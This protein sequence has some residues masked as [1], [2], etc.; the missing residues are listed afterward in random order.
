MANWP[1]SYVEEANPDFYVYTS[2]GSCIGTTVNMDTTLYVMQNNYT[3][4]SY[5]GF[6]TISEQHKNNLINAQPTI[7][8]YYGIL[9]YCSSANPNDGHHTALYEIQ[10]QSGDNQLVDHLYTIS[11]YES[12]NAPGYIL[13][14]TTCYVRNDTFT[15]YPTLTPTSTP[16]FNTL[17]PT[18]NPTSVPTYY[19]TYV[20]THIPTI[21]PTYYPTFIP[22]FIPTIHPTYDPSVPTI[23]PSLSPTLAPTEAPSHSRPTAHPTFTNTV[24]YVRKNGCDYGYCNHST[25]NETCIHSNANIYQSTCQTIEYAWNCFL[26]IG[27]D[28]NI[29]GC[30]ENGLN[31][32]GI[33]DIGIGQWY[34]PYQLHFDDNNVIIRGKESELTIFN[35]VSYNSK[36]ITCKWH[37]CWIGLHNLTIKSNR[38]NTNDIQFYMA[39]GG[40]LYV[41]NVIFDGNNYVIS[42]NKQPFWQFIEAR[43]NVE[44][45][46]CHFKNN[47]DMLTLFSNGARGLFYNCTFENNH[48]SVNI[49]MFIINASSVIF[50]KCTFM[51]NTQTIANSSLFS[52]RNGGYLSVIESRFVANVD[53][54]HNSTM[55]TTK[56]SESQL[57]ITKSSFVNTVGYKNI[58]NIYD[59]LLIINMT[60]FSGN[61]VTNIVRYENANWKSICYNCSFYDNNI[62]KIISVENSNVT[63]EKCV[64]KGNTQNTQN[65][66][67]LYVFNNGTIEIYETIFEMNIGHQSVVES[68]D[69]S[70]IIIN[71][72]IFRENKAVSIINTNDKYLWDNDKYE[73]VSDVQLDTLDVYVGSTVF[74]QNNV[75]YLLNNYGSNIY[76]SDDIIII[77]NKCDNYCI[78]STGGS[79]SI[80]GNYLNSVNNYMH[81]GH[82]INIINNISLCIRDKHNVAYSSY[83]S[84]NNLTTNSKII[85]GECWQTYTESNY[86]TTFDNYA[87]SLQNIETHVYD[88]TGA[89]T[90]QHIRCT[91]TNITLCEIYCNEST[92]CIATIT[93]DKKY[94]NLLCNQFRSCQQI[95]I[96]TDITSNTHNNN[97]LH[98]ICEDIESCE[99]ADITVRNI[100]RFELDCIAIHACINVTVNLSSTISSK[101]TCYERY[102]CDNLKVI[103]DNDYTLVTIHQFS[104]N[105]V[106]YNSLG[107]RNYNLKCGTDNAY[108]MVN[109]NQYEMMNN[110]ETIYDPMPCN[111]VKYICNG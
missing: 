17:P 1:G 65:T 14:N 60:L 62:N 48:A 12:Q 103:T 74:Q 57:H 95:K 32:N 109:N 13:T 18:F 24:V 9:G 7:Y 77:N 21:H 92:S 11:Q 91:T 63:I 99:K 111:D 82:A 10:W 6:I 53:L 55:F 98:I 38:T 71:S 50:N 42:T 85:Y 90:N 64:F 89:T 54:G 41:E 66:K 39:N 3:N 97:V 16:T 27:G 28:P 83:I 107:Y 81:F 87:V 70:K 72:C 43:V 79:M 102:S 2:L 88:E 15:P 52:V 106:I 104:K 76:V 35:Y 101:I 31:A 94:T 110:S 25:T 4:S 59:G 45:H 69:N 58:L 84:T 44:F 36:W 51:N 67:L 47:N 61:K 93:V 8:H 75:S 19:P 26:G 34:F 86:S 100:N 46:H 108:I 30:K 96:L 49:V 40:T 73:C 68:E 23:Q 22:T 78:K 80:K 105:I 5:D 20:P 37:K 56:H 33:F 29:N